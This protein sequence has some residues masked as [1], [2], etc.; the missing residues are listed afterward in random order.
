MKLK[1]LAAVAASIGV[2][3]GFAGSASAQ[4]GYSYCSQSDT[5]APLGGT[6]TFTTFRPHLEGANSHSLSEIMVTNGHGATIEFGWTVDVA[7]NGDDMPHLFVYT[8]PDGYVSGGYNGASGFISGNTPDA[9]GET[10]VLGTTHTYGIR[11]DG[12]T[13][14]LT[15]D[16]AYFGHVPDTAIAGSWNAAYLDVYAEAYNSTAVNSQVSYVAGGFT[17]VG[18]G[19]WLNAPTSNNPVYQEIDVSQSG[20]VCVGGS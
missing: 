9:P 20:M 11:H 17:N 1:I 3:L 18:G 6:V 2:T 5:S 10:L 12:G 16:G 7:L 8:T 4:A 19:T 15:Y 13:W 14:W